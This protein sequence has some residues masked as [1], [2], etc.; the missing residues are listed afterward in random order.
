MNTTLCYLKRDNQ[1]LMLYRNKKDNDVNRGKW[2]GVGGKMEHQESPEEGMIR[3]VFEETG[4]IINSHKYCGVVTFC[5]NGEAAE[6]MH[7]FT[8]ESFSGNQKESCSEGELKWVD[9]EQICNLNLWQGDRVF[10]KLLKDNCPFFSLK[11][12]YCNDDLVSAIV[13]GKEVNT[14]G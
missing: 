8:S 6:Y 4:Y 1:Y 9:I 11:L 5:Y 14:N 2:I 13:N 10:L 3:E 12:V 7:L